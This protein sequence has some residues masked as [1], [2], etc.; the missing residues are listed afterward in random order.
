M[1]SIEETILTSSKT[2]AVVGLSANP[3]RPSN[4]VAGYLLEQG[5]EIIPVNP[6]ESQILG[7]KAYPNLSS[8][9]Q[10]VDVVQIFRK[11]EDVPPIINE[12]IK[13]KAKAVWMQEGIIN[14]QAAA[15][16]KDAGLMV[17]MNKCMFKE[18]Q[19]LIGE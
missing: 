16:A 17:V 1:S 4:D 6:K 2:I 18:H 7:Q 8:I 9:P 13:I 14:E 19:K 5:Y 15:S 3:E 12:A 11:P 10:K